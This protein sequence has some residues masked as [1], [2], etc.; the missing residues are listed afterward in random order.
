M[1]K[2][3]EQI[4]QIIVGKTVIFIKPFTFYNIYNTQSYQAAARGSLPVIKGRCNSILS[5]QP[6]TDN[7]DTGRSELGE[8]DEDNMSQ[9]FRHPGQL[10][11]IDF[12]LRQKH[13]CNE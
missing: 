1:I 4:G 7:R 8:A 11:C 5:H 13:L 2:E 3:L 12:L 6:G 10:A 9:V